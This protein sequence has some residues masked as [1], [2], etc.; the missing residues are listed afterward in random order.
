VLVCFPLV[1]GLVEHMEL[2]CP[3]GLEL[4]VWACFPLVVER[5][6]QKG[7]ACS[8]GRELQESAWA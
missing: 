3:W 2:V 8:W 1:V 6:E 7:L 5:V 4:R